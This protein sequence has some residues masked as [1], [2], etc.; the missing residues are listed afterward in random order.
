MK[1]LRAD[2]DF[3]AEAELETVRKARGGID[4]D[5]GAVDGA[6]E[7][8]RRLAV[9]RD[10]SVRMLRVVAVDMRD[11]LLNGADGLHADNSVKILGPEVLLGCFCKIRKDSR[12]SAVSTFKG[13][14]Y[15]GATLQ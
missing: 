10:D 3:R 11:C 5:A 12:G 9:L 4:I 6:Q 14:R 15:P 7:Q 8:V 1:F 13:T 2:A